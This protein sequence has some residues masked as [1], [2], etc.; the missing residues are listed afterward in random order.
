[1]IKKSFVYKQMTRIIVLVIFFGW[2]LV[3]ANRA[4]SAQSPA[5]DGKKQETQVEKGKRL[6]ADLGCIVCHDIA[7]IESDIRNEAP[8]LTF[9]GEFVRPDW[10]Y[11]FL[12][13]PY[14]IRPAVKARMPDFRLTDR[15]ALALTE[16][17]GTLTHNNEPIPQALRYPRKS[18]PQEVEAAKKLISKDYFNCFNCHVLGDQKPTGKPDEWAPDLIK[19][20]SRFKP[21]FLIKWLQDAPKY[22][23]GA[24]MPAFFPDK[25]SGPDDI[26]GGDEMKQVVAIR[27]Y[28]LGLGRDETFSG[29]EQA[30]AKF[31]HVKPSE[32]RA[33]MVRLNCVGCHEVA[34][35]PLGRKVAPRLDF[36]GSRVQEPWLVDFL[37]SPYTIK[38]EYALMGNPTRMPTF[39]FTQD[40]LTAVVEYIT[41]VLVD[42]ES[43]QKLALEPGL[44]PKGEA[45]FKEKQCSD[46]HQIG[47][48]PGGIGPVLTD[49]R[50]RLRPA[51][52]V[53]FIQKPAHFLDTRM[54]NLDVTPEEAKALAAYIL[55]SKP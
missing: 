37:R 24:K 25:D 16:Y 36:Q 50:K 12:K 9:Q 53:N 43:E 19:I 49:P 41:Q 23:P 52:V 3:D 46:C 27:D 28:L 14:R 31:P 18:T 1:M 44:A 2:H 35:L 39:H 38:P 15:E 45:I 34:V 6:V 17:L 48:R 40:E 21:D 54:P 13:K 20:G 5:D 22:R 42:K 30:K 55:N 47:D 51:W 33:L 4:V 11:A 10:L 29:Y 26:L 32:G 8:N 7:G